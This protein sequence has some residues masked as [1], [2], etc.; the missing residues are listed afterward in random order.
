M[1][2]DVYERGSPM[3]LLGLNKDGVG[4]DGRGR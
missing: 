2:A 4:I 3:K 1:L